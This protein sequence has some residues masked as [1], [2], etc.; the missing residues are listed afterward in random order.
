MTHYFVFVAI[1]IIVAECKSAI[2]ADST[3]S[4]AQLTIHKVGRG[5]KSAIS[6]NSHPSSPR[7][8]EL[9][10]AEESFLYSLSLSANCLYIFHSNETLN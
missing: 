7:M 2:R 1:V 9:L 5:N 6:E 10:I 4:K 3:G 8:S